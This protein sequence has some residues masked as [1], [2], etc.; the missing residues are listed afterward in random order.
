MRPETVQRWAQRLEASSHECAMAFRAAAPRVTPSL[1]VGA[2]E[3][4]AELGLTLAQATWRGWEAAV[5][6]FR[7]SPQL[8]AR[9]DMEAMARLMGSTSRVM[10]VSPQLGIEL[11]RGAARF[12]ERDRQ[13]TL[14]E[15]VA[16]GERLAPC[17]RGGRIAAAYF[18]VSP[19]IMSLTGPHEFQEW[20]GLVRTFTDGAEATALELIRQSPKR[21]EKIPPLAR[22]KALRL[23]HTLARRDP[24]TAVEV[25]TTLTAALQAVSGALRDRLLDLALRVAETAPQ[26]LDHLLKAIARLMQGLPEREQAPLLGQCLHVALADAEAATVLCDHLPEVLGQ[27][28]A[29]DIEAWVARG[30][31]VWRDNRDG[32][33]AYFATESQ[34]CQRELAA[35]GRV[36][37]L[38]H[39]QGVLRLYALALAGRP[40][41]VRP[42][43]ELPAAFRGGTRQ[44][45]TTDG[46]AVYL[47]T[48]V[49]RFDTR[50]RN[51]RMFL[52]MT[53]HQAGY[54]EFGTFGF[55]LEVLTDRLAAESVELGAE[56]WQDSSTAQPAPSRSDF[57]RFFSKFPRPSVARDVFYSLEDGRIDALLRRNYRGLAPHIGRII[58]D[59][60]ATR[61]PL[62]GRPL[63]GAL[64][65][66]LIHLC[67]TGRLAIKVPSVLVPLA[68]FLRSVADR[69]RQPQATVYD[70]AI[71]TVE[72]YRLLEQ[73]PNVRVAALD[74]ASVDGDLVTLGELLSKDAAVES[75]RDM[76]PSIPAGEEVA[77]QSPDPL[78]HQGEF[79]PDLI[80]RKLKVQELNDKLG[81]LTKTATPMSPE[82]LRE[83]LEHGVDIDIRGTIAQE[84]DETSGFF[85]SDLEGKGIPERAEPKSTRPGIDHGRLREQLSEELKQLG[86]G[87]VVYRYDEWD[88]LMRDYRV[89]WCLLREK[90]VE[91]E[92]E[93]FVAG[94]LQEDAGL[95]S[96]IRKQFQW[97]KP[98]MFKKLKRRDHGE[99]IDIDAAI[100]GF[101]DRRVTGVAPER[102]YIK[103]DKR[104]REV[105]TVF[106]LDLSASTDDPIEQPATMA[107]S[108]VRRQPPHAP[109]SGSSGSVKDDGFYAPPFA[110]PQQKPEAKRIIDVEKE[111]LVVMAEALESIG[112][113]Y[114]VYG[115][116]GYGRVNVEFFIV[117]EVEERYSEAVK[118]RIDVLKP[119]RSTRMGPA[120]RHAIQKL[121]RRPARLKTLL[122]LS[123]GYPQDFDYGKDRRGKDYGIQDTKIALQE[124][125]RK[126]IHTFCIT[127]DH[128]GKSYLP[129]M[130]GEDKFIV[131][132]N[133]ARLPQLLPKI[134][135]GLTT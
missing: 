33:L 76:M 62:T 67:G 128:E 43:T 21:L 130:C 56:W 9:L 96:Q 28:A 81:Q 55:A 86:G 123:D 37:Y 98:E 110:A 46:E 1:D 72:V 93:G 87:E 50:E 15:W 79:K 32:G 95:I 29:C 11:L 99:D 17:G 23:V 115:F 92:A 18:E 78:P 122:L 6:Y 66:V 77:Y 91:G 83:L 45:P 65:E 30:L 14:R 64:I 35:L 118:R 31:A 19:E 109:R 12:V 89:Q 90:P 57:E 7:L 127:V 61:P 60:L 44:F 121:Y 134:Y 26:H 104:E 116:S 20:G 94:V 58:R 108:T 40:L 75:F 120:I 112:D 63:W 106:L 133:V 125:R 68:R 85:V 71:G 102:V 70:S 34:A 101:V 39:A 22:P 10:E 73:L 126:G 3:R 54:L 49:E 69:V 38:P 42:L 124:A 47:P 41:R 100:E 113:D 119:Y 82:L 129:E 84:Q 51:F 36:A 48:S 97:L 2:F 59:G 16:A 114:A 111:A 27:L 135:R 24:A 88:Y 13:V 132:E 103:R 25:L 107:T 131:I 105:S 8:L 80:Q 53:A 74:D 5:W 117:K 4:W 52:V